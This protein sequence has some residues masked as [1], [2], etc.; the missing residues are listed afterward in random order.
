VLLE[1]KLPDDI[2]ANYVYSN[3]G[4]LLLGRVVEQVTQ[5]S[6][7]D[8]LRSEFNIDVHVAG[9]TAEELRNNE[10]YYY[11]HSQDSC[12]T[13]PLARLDSACG[14]IISPL[15]LVKFADS[16]PLS[17]ISQRGSLDGNECLL[18]KE[19]GYTFAAFCNKRQ[20][21]DFILP[22]GQLFDWI[23]ANIDDCS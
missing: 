18:V 2:G 21:Y 13:M 1:T 15:D 20:S 23:K 7:I 5:M 3:F 8:F 14:L 19:N 9:S 6:Y 4:Y 22:L 10:S 12:F 17:S 16:L 11:N